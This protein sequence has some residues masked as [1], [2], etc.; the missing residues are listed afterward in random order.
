MSIP[1]FFYFTKRGGEL[2]PFKV[3]L[4]FLDVIISTVNVPPTSRSRLS[5]A[6][7]CVSAKSHEKTIKT[8]GLITVEER[9]VLSVTQIHS[10][11]FTDMIKHICCLILTMTVNGTG[12][13]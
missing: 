2:N 12:L 9:K 13:I 1:F 3:F 8:F 10:L 6:R 4:V 5:P 7:V 11:D